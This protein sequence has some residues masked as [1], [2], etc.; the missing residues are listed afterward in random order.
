M[1]RINKG[2]WALFIPAAL[3]ITA[4]LKNSLLLFALVF[5]AHF[6]IIKITPAF[7]R[8][9]NVWMFVMVAI[10]SIPL[11]LLILF[12][13]NDFGML[14]DS[15]FILGVFRCILYYAILFSMEQIIMGV[16]SRIICRR[17][18]KLFF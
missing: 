16:L 1:F 15:M 13:M 5:L 8:R 6:I 17:Q 11:N 14:F 7:K 10:S 9:E 2:I 4:V 18:Y 12:Y 3:S